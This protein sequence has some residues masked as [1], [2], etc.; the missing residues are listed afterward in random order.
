MLPIS[1][2]EFECIRLLMDQNPIFLGLSLPV[3]S[4]AA[5]FFKACPRLCLRRLIS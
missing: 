3:P 2:D 5:M 4:N 1:N